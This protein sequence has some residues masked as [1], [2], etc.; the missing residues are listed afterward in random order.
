MAKLFNNAGEKPILPSTLKPPIAIAGV[1]SRRI[2]GA[3][4]AI[5]LRDK[6]LRASRTLAAPAHDAH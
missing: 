6:E 4:R 1:L 2:D 3:P 5:P